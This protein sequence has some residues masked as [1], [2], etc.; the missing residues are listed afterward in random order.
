MR[1]YLFLLTMLAGMATTAK[2][3]VFVGGTGG[4]GISD[5]FSMELK[6]MVGYQFND[7]WAIG[8]GVGMGLLDREISGILDPFVRFNCWNNGKVHFDLKARS[9]IWFGDISAMKVGIVPSLRVKLNDKWQLAGDI[10]LVGA[11]YANEDW[12]PAILVT[13]GNVEL[14]VVYS[15]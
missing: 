14:T 10:G 9:E 5:V 6:P 12:T 11:Q 8:A 7:R 3:Q 1:K 4:I 2:S 13:G 15:F